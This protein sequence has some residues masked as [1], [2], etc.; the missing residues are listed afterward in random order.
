VNRTVMLVVG[1]AAAVIVAAVIGIAIEEQ[2]AGDSATSANRS[3]FTFQ[4]TGYQLKSRPDQTSNLY[5]KYRYNDD[6]PD[7][8]IP[9]YRKLRTEALNYLD[10]ADGSQHLEVLNKG[11]CNKLKAD[12]PVEAISCQ[13]QALP[14]EAGV[15]PETGLQRN[16]FSAVYTI[17]DIAP[18]DVAGAV[19]G[20]PSGP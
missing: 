18:L 8:D 7:A 9:D 1:V 17:G 20:A 15:A 4:Q 19:F 14:K 2:S 3:E 16:T 11:M 12:F 5:F 6:L 13:L 10:G